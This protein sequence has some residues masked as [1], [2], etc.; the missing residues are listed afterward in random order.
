M[1]FVFRVR[2][3]LVVYIIINLL[4]KKTLFSIITGMGGLQYEVE[5]FRIRW[6]QGSQAQSK[7]T[8]ETRHTHV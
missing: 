3:R 4:F 6:C 1:H 2:L 5:H 7:P 8:V